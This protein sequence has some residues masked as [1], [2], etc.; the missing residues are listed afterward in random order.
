MSKQDYYE[1]LGLAKTA[2]EDE[3][4]KAYRKLAMKFH[5]DRNQG[6]GSKKA[7]EQFKEVKEA[8]EHLS[9]KD[10]RVEYD[11]YGHSSNNKFQHTWSNSHDDDS[12]F[13]DIFKDIFGG[14]SNFDNIFRQGTYNPP[15]PKSQIY[16][17][18]ISLQDAYIGKY[19]KVD[20]KTA[21]QI[22]KGVRPGT[23]FYSGGKI[24]QVNIQPHHKF[25]RSNDDLLVDI[26]INAF[27]AMLG[28]EVIFEHLDNTKLQFNIPAGIQH[29]QVIKLASKGMK[30]PETDKIGDLLIRCSIAIPKNLTEEQK[31][32]LKKMSKRTSI[33]I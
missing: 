26:D 2:T 21:I 17:I 23:K 24:Y 28:L 30:N 16:A 14:N 9:D 32:M 6:E 18:N 1:V 15:P 25:K 27:E 31:D 8:Y 22:P 10:K 3:I 19:L 7:E 13:K 29:G 33:N 5:P 4:K 11:S 20:S 12:V